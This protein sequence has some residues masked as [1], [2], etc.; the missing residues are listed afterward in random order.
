MS[1]ST[2]KHRGIKLNFLSLTMLPLVPAGASGV[3]ALLSYLPKGTEG[4]FNVG[5]NWNVNLE[6]R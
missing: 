5:T 6:K 1:R 4:P 2:C 3:P